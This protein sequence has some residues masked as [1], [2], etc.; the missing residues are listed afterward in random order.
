MVIP[1]ITTP[2]SRPDSY[3]EMRVLGQ[4]PSGPEGESVKQRQSLLASHF[5]KE[6]TEGQM[7]EEANEY[8]QSFFHKVTKLANQVGFSGW[9]SPF[10]DNHPSSP[11]HSLWVS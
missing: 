2:E 8:R 4:I 5:W 3:A 7:F 9:S 1:F 10:E 11:R 6:I